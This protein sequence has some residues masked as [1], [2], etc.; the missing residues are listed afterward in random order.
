[1]QTQTHRRGA[2]AIKKSRGASSSL[3]V[4]LLMGLSLVMVACGGDAHIQQQATQ[5]KA[6]LD[7][8]LQHAQAIGIPASSLRLII[9]Q[10]RQLSSTS[11]PFNLFND[12]PL[13]NYNQNL[14]THYT[15]LTVQTQNIVTT[16]TDQAQLLA[17]HD[18]QN[19][20]T[21]LTQARMLS[22]PIQSFSQQFS[23]D[24]ALLGAAKYPKDYALVSSK[25]KTAQQTLTVLQD[26][27]HQL[28]TFQQTIVQMQQAHIDVTAMQTQYQDDQQSLPAI[29]TMTE[30]SPQ[31]SFSGK[32]P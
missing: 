21:S 32:L 30:A 4:L 19:F 18:L 8:L 22:L 14:A 28:H 23:Q 7:Q 20:Q 26:V 17:Q 24:Q 10:E 13:N 29:K 5:N 11:A 31:A 16:Y 6:Q 9:T 25:A 15:Q 1:M 3:L 27:A 2:V 12:Q